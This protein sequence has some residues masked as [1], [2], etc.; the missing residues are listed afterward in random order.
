MSAPRRDNGH[1]KV[2]GVGTNEQ[3]K[4]HANNN[5]AQAQRQRL[6]D[7]LRK[8]PV[9]TIEARRDLDLMMPGTRIH[10]LRH[11]HGHLI[12]M[13]WVQKPMDSGKLHRVGLYILRPADTHEGGAA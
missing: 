6:L 13:I 10:E 4:L 7:A 2:A 5:S 12:D 11:K 1:G 8:G 9:S 3:S